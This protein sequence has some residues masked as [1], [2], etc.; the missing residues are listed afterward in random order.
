MAFSSVSVAV[1]FSD[2]TIQ[3][4]RLTT[5]YF[6]SFQPQMKKTTANIETPGNRAAVH[7]FQRVSR[8]VPLMW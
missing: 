1:S 7:S 2:G 4:M 8:T 6:K 3:C 5:W